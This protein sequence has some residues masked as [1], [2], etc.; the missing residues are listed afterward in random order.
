MLD[1]TP[2]M[3]A[4]PVPR[5]ALALACLAGCAHAPKAGTTVQMDPIVFQAKPGGAVEVKDLAE[6]FE[7]ASAAYNAEAL[8]L[9]DAI[10]AEHPGTQHARSALY[11]A[12]LALEQLDR[13]ADAAQ[14]YERLASE[15]PDSPEALDALFRLGSTLVHLK[16][17]A[18]SE[19]A[20]A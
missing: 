4:A 19:A 13:R 16:E 12:G 14:R 1:Q 15:Y 9:F 5:L 18:R 10:A 6:P 2:R 7:K 11:N 20:H 3:P 17:W 8:A